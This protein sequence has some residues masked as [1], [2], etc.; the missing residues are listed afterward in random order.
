[1]AYGIY[2]GYQ[3]AESCYLIFCL[4][5]LPLN[6]DECQSKNEVYNSV[7]LLE[8]YESFNQHIL[9][10]YHWKPTPLLYISVWIMPYLL[11]LNIVPYT[12]FSL[13]HF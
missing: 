3:S 9:Y 13:T 6:F 11:T 5:D 2:G 7:I 1:M 10:Q 12:S 8:V 4:K